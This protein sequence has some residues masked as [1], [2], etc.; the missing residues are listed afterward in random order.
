MVCL[1]NNRTGVTIYF[2]SKLVSPF[3]VTLVSIALFHP[4]L[5]FFY[6]LLDGLF[7]DVL[8]M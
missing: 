1:K 7:W 6:A 8:C 3:T 4:T 2:N 5:P